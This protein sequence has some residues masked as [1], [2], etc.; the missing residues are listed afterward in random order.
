LKGDVFEDVLAP[1]YY[2]YAD[3]GENP[4]AASVFETGR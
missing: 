1:V 2:P 3:G 4:L